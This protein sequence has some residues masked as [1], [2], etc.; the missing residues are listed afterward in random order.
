MGQIER[1]YRDDIDSNVGVSKGSSC[2]SPSMRPQ[3]WTLS[4]DDY[5]QACVHIYVPPLYDPEIQGTSGIIFLGICFIHAYIHTTKI[6]FQI[7]PGI[8]HRKQHF[9]DQRVFLWDTPPSQN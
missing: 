4:S 7:P 9:L 6:L 8:L 3:R 5:S 1:G 2:M